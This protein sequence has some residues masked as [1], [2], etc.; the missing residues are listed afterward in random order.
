[1][2]L[3]FPYVIVPHV[4]VMDLCAASAFDTI[5]GAKALN[6]DKKKG[7]QNF[8]PDICIHIYLCI[9]TH[10]IIREGSLTFYLL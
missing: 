3:V 4:F 2:L 9:Y 8:N 7:R 5:G 6:I 10:K 1:M